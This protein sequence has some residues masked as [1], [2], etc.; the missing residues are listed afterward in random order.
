MYLFSIYLPI[1]IFAVIL[2]FAFAL[3]KARGNVAEYDER[4]L[5]IRGKGYQYGF[6]TSLIYMF[7]I[8]YLDYTNLLDNISTTVVIMVGIF[9][10]LLVFAGYCIIKDAFLS[11]TQN[12]KHYMILCCVIVIIDAL[13]V[14]I[15]I[16]ENKVIQNGAINSN[17]LING[18]TGLLFAIMLVLLIIKN[19]ISKADA[20]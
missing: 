19:I 14:F 7:I 11:L 12:R 1:I 8:V 9:L 13:N 6:L 3:R 4:Q 2:L 17:I 18:L 15:A 10:S 16:S 5:V 20:E